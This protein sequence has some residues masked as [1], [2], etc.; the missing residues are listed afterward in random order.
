MLYVVLA[1]ALLL[2]AVA[3]HTI[4]GFISGPVPFDRVF[5]YVKRA[6]ASPQEVTSTLLKEAEVDLSVVVPAYNE[7]ERIHPMLDEALVYLENR[8]KPFTYEVIVVDDGSS[9]GTYD[10]ISTKNPNI[11]RIELSQNMGKGFAVKV[12]VLAAR[13]RKILM[14]D[15]DGATKFED[16]DRLELK[17]T[18]C[19]FGSRSHLQDEALAKRAW[20]RNILMIAFHLVVSFIVGTSIRDTQCGFKLFKRPC[21]QRLFPSLHINRW[22]FDIELVVL[23]QHLSFTVDEVPVNWHEVPG[24]KL[25]IIVALFQMLRDIIAIKLLYTLK[26]WHPA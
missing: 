21:A 26:V 23:S 17:T 20:Y 5:H 12:G 9:D 24:S 4:I 3:F 25:N 1:I 22:A 18:D 10:T 15:A 6:W 16:L 2:G 13:G 14:V 11:R 8:K 19:V 7:A